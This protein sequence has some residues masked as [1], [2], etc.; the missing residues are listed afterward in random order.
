MICWILQVSLSELFYLV[1]KHNYGWADSH[2]VCTVKS[3]WNGTLGF[4]LLYTQFLI[5]CYLIYLYLFVHD[6]FELQIVKYTVESSWSWAQLAGFSSVH[7]FVFRNGNGR[8]DTD[9]EWQAVVIK[10][11]CEHTF[12]QSAGMSIQKSL[13]EV[14]QIQCEFWLLYSCPCASPAH[15]W[16]WLCSGWVLYKWVSSCSFGWSFVRSSQKSISECG[17]GQHSHFP[18]IL[19]ETHINCESEL[20]TPL[21]CH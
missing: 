13:T 15:I 1:V 5:A 8:A 3:I 21:S 9:S 2:T 20:W 17:C 18:G 19:K 11:H 6:Q 4:F 12:M 14:S 16:E 7:K 10:M